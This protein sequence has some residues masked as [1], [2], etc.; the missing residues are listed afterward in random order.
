MPNT[1]ENKPVGKSGQR[2]RKGE[3]RRQKSA[4]PQS[5]AP[6]QLLSP[7]PE[8]REP[9]QL[10]N[11]EPVQLQSPEPDQLES[12]EPDQ[13]PDAVERIEAIAAPPEA[14]RIGAAEAADTAAVSLRTIANA[15]SDYTRRSLEE[16]RSYVE[17]LKG[18]R[19]LGK[20]MEVQSD[21]ARHAYENFFAD[22]QKIYELQKELAR[23]MFK[24]L[25]SLVTRRTRDPR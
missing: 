3:Q 4:S 14:E 21:F 18:A 16:T 5:P 7:E 8:S 1:D 23:Q 9:D 22:S 11:P 15:Y 12:P 24:P 19:S 17:R 6:E 20:A 13:P 2:S 25:E 10:Q